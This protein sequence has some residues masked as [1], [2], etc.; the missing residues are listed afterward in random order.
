MPSRSKNSGELVG[1]DSRQLADEL[2]AVMDEQHEFLARTGTGPADSHSLQV[3]CDA[4]PCSSGTP[5]ASGNC[6]RPKAAGRSRRAA[7]DEGGERAAIPKPVNP[8]P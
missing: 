1:P 8:V 7:G 3:L 6:S 4:A 5:T 2:T